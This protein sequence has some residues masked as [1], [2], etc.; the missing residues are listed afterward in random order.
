MSG[1][2]KAKEMIFSR[3]IEVAVERYLATQRLGNSYDFTWIE[4]SGA[5]SLP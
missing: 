3:L 5:S 4:S 2:T 1:K